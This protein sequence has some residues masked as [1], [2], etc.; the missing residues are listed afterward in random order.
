[1]T[2][3]SQDHAEAVAALTEHRAPVFHGR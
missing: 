3:R 2:F 1:M